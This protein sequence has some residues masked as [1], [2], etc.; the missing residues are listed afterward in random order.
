MSPRNRAA[1]SSILCPLGIACIVALAAT[2]ASAQ[3]PTITPNF[4][5]F[6]ADQTV[7][8]A[9]GCVVLTWHVPNAQQVTLSGSNWPEGTKE[10]VAQ[11]GSTTVCPS[12]ALN[13]VRGEPVTY[14]LT[15]I[16]MTNQTT[17]SRI[18]ITYERQ[19]VNGY[20]PTE[21]FHPPASYTYSPP[22]AVATSAAMPATPTA[23][24]D[25]QIQAFE[26]GWMLWRKDTDTVLVLIGDGSMAT[27]TFDAAYPVPTGT[28]LPPL[29]PEHPALSIPFDVVW[30]W[31][32][33]IRAQ[34]GWPTS[35]AR[36]YSAT[37]FGEV[38]L[39]S[40]ITLPDGR[41]VNLSYGGSWFMV[42]KTSG[43]WSISG[44]PIAWNTPSYPTLTPTITPTPVLVE[45]VYQPF[46]NGFMIAINNSGCAFI[47][48][49]SPDKTTEGI[50]IP[51]DILATPDIG[52][53][54]HYCQEF[55][56]LPDNPITK[57]PPSE[58]INPSGAFGRI[59]GYFSDVRER[60]GYATEP[61][62]RYTSRIPSAPSTYGGGPFF[63]PQLSL[64]D[65]RVLWCGF[66]AATSGSCYLE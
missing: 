56:A 26:N 14:R 17:I 53:S 63:I 32:P 5:I 57:A 42:G 51:R 65:G 46:E 29:P 21:P 24:I 31:Y 27:I 59:W 45:A 52:S 64:P 60:L 44:L 3:S 36:Q 58:L 7:I 13:Y 35:P 22:T 10:S 61:A 4:T 12:A 40:G 25:V 62:Q 54:Y 43:S 16:D 20:V 6:T 19:I 38:M 2:V 49:Y 39:G 50:L 33:E 11:S 28:P 8:P 15:V 47:Y 41:T 48:V 9:G 1:L 34:I 30:N 66:R 37:V 23:V 55:E 18:V